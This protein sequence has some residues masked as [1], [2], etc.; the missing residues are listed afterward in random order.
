MKVTPVE[1]RVFIENESIV[2]FICEHIPVIEENAVL[3]VTSKIVALAEG[4]TEEF[5]DEKRKV[6]LICEESEEAMET[7]WCW[8]TVKDGI[9]MPSAGIDESNS[10]G[11]K[12]ILLPKDSYEAADKI[13]NALREKF[14]LNSLGIIL[15]DSR[16]MP[17]RAGV[18]GVPLGYAGIKGIRDYIEEKDI[19]GREMKMARTNVV[20]CLSATAVLLMGEC[21]EQIPLVVIEDAP[22]EFCDHVDRDELKIDIEDDLYKPFFGSR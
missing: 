21:A 13:R 6:E 20:D 18:T 7:K 8:L 1:T 5:V 15:T 9:L 22:V 19:F 17:F 4:R 2:D 12:L 11:G 16:I 10:A 14:Q 3:A